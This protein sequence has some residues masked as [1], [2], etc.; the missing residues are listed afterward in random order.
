MLPSAYN[1]A[2]RRAKSVQALPA[3]LQQPSHF[4]LPT[5]KLPSCL[6]SNCANNNAKQFSPETIY[7]VQPI[8]PGEVT[9][10]PPTINNQQRVF[11]PPSNMAYNP[12]H[13]CN[14]RAANITHAF[15]D[16][17]VHSPTD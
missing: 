3:L 13:H 4:S 7:A 17:D 6:S 1:C 5:T 14:A 15:N 10:C 8:L 11:E 12:R 16:D 2:V 9:D